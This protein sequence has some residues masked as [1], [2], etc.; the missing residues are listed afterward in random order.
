MAYRRSD[1]EIVP[2]HVVYNN[3][4]TS[5]SI[6][7]SSTKEVLLHFASEAC[8][9]DDRVKAQSQELDKRQKDTPHVL[10]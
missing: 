6:W 5:S 7:R 9:K 3:S 4:I 1:R 8:E 10:L 2:I